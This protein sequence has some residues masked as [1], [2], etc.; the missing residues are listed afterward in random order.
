VGSSATNP[1]S[2]GF[3]KSIH[4][5]F[6]DHL[7]EA[8][9]KV[10]SKEGKSKT[11][12]P[13]E[14]RTDEVEVGRHIAPLAANVPL[15]MDRFESYYDVRHPSNSSRIRRI[16]SIAAAH[17]R[18]AWIHPFLDGNGRVVRL[19]SDAAFMAEGLAASGL[20]SVS[21]GLARRKSDYYVWLANADQPRYNDHDGRGNLSD[22]MLSGFCD[23]F[24]HTAIDQINFMHQSLNTETMLERISNFADLMIIRKKL[25]KEAKYI[26]IDLFLKGSITKSDTMRIT[27]L[28][29][30]TLKDLTDT[31]AAMGL[32]YIGK[33]GVQVVYHVSYPIRYSAML[34]P[35]LYPGDKEADMMRV[36]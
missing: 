13:G 2:S 26:L 30:K 27:A 14:W 23:F 29:D 12:L 32:L 35:G 15:F 19:F 4:R 7:P 36:L 22:K 24:L 17:H 16:I 34:F 9:R 33:D 20:W 28:S 5:R 18:L 21:R 31:L 8:F 25:R 6:Y 3:I 11:V 10:T 1:F